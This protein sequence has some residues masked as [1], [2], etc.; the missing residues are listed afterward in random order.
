[1]TTTTKNTRRSDWEKLNFG[2]SID[3]AV[4]LQVF[5]RADMGVEPERPETDEGGCVYGKGHDLNAAELCEFSCHYGFCPESL[6]TC[7]DRGDIL[8][9]PGVVDTGEF[10]A[11]DVFD[12]DLN[13]LCKFA[14]KYGFCPDDV[15][16][17]PVI[18][19][20]EDPTLEDGT[21]ATPTTE[22]DL[23]N[24]G[25]CFIFKDPKYREATMRTCHSACG[26]K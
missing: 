16:T 17:R 14:C 20:F 7:L 10:I 3:W 19:E 2:G 11:W 1:M 22:A 21:L 26:I 23:A 24:R 15:C 9:L 8:G 13:R 12:V 18:D 25:N 4:D 5:G 6:C